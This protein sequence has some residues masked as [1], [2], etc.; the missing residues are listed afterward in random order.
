MIA[1]ISFTFKHFSGVR[2]DI[3]E[4]VIIIELIIKIG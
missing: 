2:I 4:I 1:P 3:Y